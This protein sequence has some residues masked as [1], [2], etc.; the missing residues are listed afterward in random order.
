MC[1]YCR[2]IGTFP[3]FKALYA[4]NIRSYFEISRFNNSFHPSPS[5]MESSS[6][7]MSVP[8]VSLG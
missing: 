4:N 3:V 1:C 8:H 2:E 7:V 6:F 5:L